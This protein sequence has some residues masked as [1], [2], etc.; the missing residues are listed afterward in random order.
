MKGRAF[1]CFQASN[2][3]LSSVSYLSPAILLF[4]VSFLFLFAAVDM[5]AEMMGTKDFDPSLLT[6]S[7]L[8]VSVVIAIAF[9]LL[10]F[11][12][13]DKIG[14]FV[15]I[16]IMMIG[17]ALFGIST[18][19]IDMKG[20]SIPLLWFILTGV[21]IYLGYLPPCSLLYDRL[22]PAL[23]ISSTCTFVVSFSDFAGYLGTVALLFYRNF[24]TSSSSY[25]TFFKGLSLIVC[26]I[27][28][29]GLA[30]T[31]VVLLYRFGM[32]SSLKCCGAQ[33]QPQQNEPKSHE[34]ILLGE[35][36]ASSSEH[37]AERKLMDSTSPSPAATAS[38]SIV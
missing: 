30:I 17:F 13:N 32:V 26:F 1:A 18:I 8:V 36:P 37:D 12:Q 38:P 27:G 9:S 5:W 23:G 19:L 4:F 15:C 28:L 3:L 2:L 33:Q 14:T 21:S 24:A 34:R 11:I 22:I 35:V 25:C 7:E 29:I 6:E 20:E 16:L 10:V 31:V